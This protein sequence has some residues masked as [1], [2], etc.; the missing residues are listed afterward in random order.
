MKCDGMRK[1]GRATGMINKFNFRLYIGIESKGTLQISCIVIGR[2]KSAIQIQ[3]KSS[4]AI[5]SLDQEI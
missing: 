2:K 4:I 5:F 1:I 3:F